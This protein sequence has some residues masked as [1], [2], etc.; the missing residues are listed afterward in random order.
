MTRDQIITL[1]DNLH[2]VPWP[3]AIVLGFLWSVLMVRFAMQAAR[4]HGVVAIPSKRS[5]HTIPTPRLGGVGI[6]AS[7][8][9]VVLVIEFMR[10]FTG[11]ARAVGI[12]VGAAYALVG[13]L[14]DDV[15]DLPPLV[16]FLFQAS[17]AASA[18]LLGADP[19]AID[20]PGGG[21]A[22]MGTALSIGFIIFMMNAYNFMDGMDGQAAVFGGC[23]A[24]AMLVTVVGRHIAFGGFE[25]ICLAA[26]IG[27]LGGFFL[28]NHPWKRS[29]A[30]TFMGDSG[31][32]MMGYLLAVMAL[33]LNAIGQ[34]ALPLIA[35]LIIL[36]PFWYDV[37][38][39][40][41]RRLVKG[42]NVVQP[43]RSHL[44]Q[45]LLVA[46]WSH[47]RALLLNAFFYLVFIGLGLAYSRIP[48]AEWAPRGAGD[49]QLLVVLTA[50]LCL[51]LY[52]LFVILC[53]RPP[54][55]SNPDSHATEDR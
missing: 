16:K 45:R 17:A 8:F 21:E 25:A 50:A 18:V 42:E 49:M 5:S 31:S 22:V 6:A 19:G 39:T 13:G 27:S 47:G 33:R 37:L 15:A 23:V 20:L 30:K 46:G 53:E 32:Q 48:V 14:L 35:S 26:A 29:E 1:Y 28:F 3:Q 9:L 38:Y 52:T 51:A 54:E 40:L 55:A 7:F 10:P 11:S 24:A 43:H 4:T 34:P 44:Y 12:L 41:A 2:T 36:A